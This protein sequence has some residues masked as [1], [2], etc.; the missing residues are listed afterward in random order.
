MTR[1]AL[2]EKDDYGISAWGMDAIMD[3]FPFAG[4]P[5]FRRQRPP[6]GGCQVSKNTLTAA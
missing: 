1:N 6:S 3:A 5:E 4:K 2:L